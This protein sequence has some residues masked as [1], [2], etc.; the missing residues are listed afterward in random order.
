MIEALPMV[1]QMIDDLVNNAPNI[2]TWVLTEFKDPKVRLVKITSEAEELKSG[3][4]SLDY[5]GGGDPREQALKGIELCRVSYILF[6][7]AIEV[8][9]DHMPDNGVLLVV[10][11]AGS[12]QRKLEKSIREKSLEKNVRITFAFSPFC[13]AS[14][15]RSLP[16]YE[17]LSDGRMFNRSGF[18][19]ESFFKS[20]VHTVRIHFLI[21]WM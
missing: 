20:V 16:I 11:D 21:C 15:R 6:C 19:S 18:T 3:L 17:R 2:P 12:H 9:L 14:C 7:S 1:K 13:R 8:T 4:F 5:G 10:T